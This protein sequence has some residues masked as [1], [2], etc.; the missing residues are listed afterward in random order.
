M[1]QL[2]F[3]EYLLWVWHTTSQL[4]Y[5]LGIIRASFPGVWLV[6]VYRAHHSKEYPTIGVQYSVIPSWILNNPI[7]EI[8]FCKWNPMEQ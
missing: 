7:F 1:K 8:V 5:E 2:T 6:H 4:L 3:P